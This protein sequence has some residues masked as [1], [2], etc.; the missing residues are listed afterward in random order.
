LSLVTGQI[1]GGKEFVDNIKNVATKFPDRVASG[2]YKEAQI[3]MTESKRRCPVMPTAAQLRMMGR[4]MPKNAV[5]G[6]L[7]ST[8][9]VHDPVRR[10]RSIS[11][12]MS[13]GA[14]GA[15]S[16]AVVQHE[17]LDF[18]HVNGQAKYLESV[19]KESQPYMGARI[20]ARV[21]FDKGTE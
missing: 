21:H 1:L 8:G 12:T 16:Y 6:L 4:S 19:L 9:T 5:P 13:Y 7:R 10:G 20:A 18:F 17:R 3:E 15:E 2:I 11:V 14:G